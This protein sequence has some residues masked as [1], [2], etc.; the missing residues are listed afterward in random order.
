MKDPVT[1]KTGNPWL[2]TAGIF[3]D[4][5]T[6]DEFQA[7]I[8]EYRRQQAEEDAARWVAEDLAEEATTDKAA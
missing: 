6:W 4:D 5:P 1:G 3:A 8:P 2:D 7:N